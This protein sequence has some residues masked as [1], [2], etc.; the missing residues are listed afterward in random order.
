LGS[1][2]S[3]ISEE[4]ADT[5]PVIIGITEVKNKKVLSDLV[6]SKNL[7]NEAYNYVH[8]DSLDE[9]GIDV[10]LLCKSSDFK[11]EHSKTFS[12]Y[13][14]TQSGEQDY[15]RDILLVQGILN[16]EP[17]HIIVNHWPSRREEEKE[18]E[19]KRLA[20]SNKVNA[21]IK[22]IKDKRKPTLR[23]I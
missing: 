16:N 11:V 17:L 2:I 13:L 22:T 6:Q 23:S 10:A 21:I 3:N 12:V 8:Y 19:F 15:T 7:I 1:V 5:A 9:R 20:A 4:N 14:Q 18:T